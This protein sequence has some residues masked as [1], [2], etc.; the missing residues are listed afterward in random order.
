MRS[1]PTRSTA[2][3]TRRS[4]PTERLAGEPRARPLECGAIDL[5]P[6]ATLAVVDLDAAGAERGGRG[7]P[8]VD[9]DDRVGAAVGDERA[10]VRPPGQIGVPAGD[11]RDESGEAEQTG[12]RRA[13]RVERKRIR[14]HGALREAAEHCA[15]GTD[16]GALP[17][18]VVERSE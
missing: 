9:R 8:E 2:R 4:S 16:S 5:V 15:L 3:P 11:R 14:H 12:G 18:L 1:R 17:D 7:A 6:A 13:T 10:E